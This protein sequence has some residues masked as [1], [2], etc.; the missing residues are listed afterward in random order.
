MVVA[1][2]GRTLDLAYEGLYEGGARQFFHDYHTAEHITDDAATGSV[3]VAEI[4]G[5]IVG[6]GTLKADG[7]VCRVYIEPG[8]QRRGVGRRIVTALLA[9]AAAAGHRQLRLC[10]SPVSRDFWEALGCRLEKECRLDFEDGNQLPYYD[11]VLDVH[12]SR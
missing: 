5:A 2:V 8:F 3:V 9:H 10:A 7:E 12:T 1:L 11:M 6:T 4:G